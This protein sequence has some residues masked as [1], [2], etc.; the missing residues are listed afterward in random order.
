MPETPRLIRINPTIEGYSHL[1]YTHDEVLRSLGF[2][3][4]SKPIDY[5]Q[6]PLDNFFQI[7]SIPPEAARLPKDES[8]LIAELTENANVINT[9]LRIPFPP[10]IRVHLG[11]T[12]VSGHEDAGVY[13][14][15]QNAV[16]LFPDWM[17]GIL[18]REQVQKW[19]SITDVDIRLFMATSSLAHELRHAD[20][21]QKGHH[22]G[23]DMSA[24]T[25]PLHQAVAV[26]GQRMAETIYGL[27]LPTRLYPEIE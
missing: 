15:L 23:I 14:P 9:I 2:K 7:Y 18:P 10:Q 16:E 19:K 11:V 21:I 24:Q 13:Y 8:G 25:H 12:Q 26:W 6:L 17:V 20:D 27:R 22:R 5:L 4:E 3:D 1:H